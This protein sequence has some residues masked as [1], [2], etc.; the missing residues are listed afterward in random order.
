MSDD[1]GRRVKPEI[2]SSADLAGERSA[3]QVPGWQPVRGTTPRARRSVAHPGPSVSRP[4]VAARARARA[5]A[6]VHLRPGPRPANRDRAGRSLLPPSDSLARPVA[7][8]A[9][10]VSADGAA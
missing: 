6:G 8:S 2:H 5:D 9:R 1:L 7:G 10:R 3:E 4:S